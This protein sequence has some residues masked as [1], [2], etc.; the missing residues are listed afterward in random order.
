MAPPIDQLT[1]QQ[2]DLQF[3]TNTLGHLL[4]IRLLYPL[5]VSTTTP[6]DPGRIVWISSSIHYLFNPPIKYE[7]ITDTEVRREQDP[8]SLYGQSKFAIVQLVRA[9]QR[10]LCEDDGVVVFSVDPG[11]IKTGLQRHNKSIIVGIL[12]KP[13]P[14]LRFLRLTRRRQLHFLLGSDVGLGALTQLYAAAEP[15]A[16]Q[17]KGGH[18]CPWA[19]AEEPHEG[20]KDV[21]EQKKLWDYCHGILKPWLA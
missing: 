15:S 8:L 18:L 5:L 2:L 9:L 10:E 19:R 14:K 13:R 3:G 21:T 12:V 7:W 17:Y 6:E 16:L 11:F 4:F 20:T 1:A